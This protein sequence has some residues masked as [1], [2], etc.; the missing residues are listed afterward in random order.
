MSP[1]TVIIPAHNEQAVIT[2][3]L[4]LILKD[5][6]SG[7][8]VEIIVAA[9]GCSDR[10]AEVARAA[11]PSAQVLELHEG[12][13]TAAINAA[14]RVARHFPRIYLDADV[15][16]DFRS[17]AALAEVLR[18]DGVMTA[19]PAIRMDLAKCNVFMRAYYR[20]WLRQ[21]YARAGRGGAGCYGL[22]KAALTAVDEFPRIIADDI[23]IHARFPDSQKRYIAHNAA[24]LPVLSTVHPPRTAWQQIK[25]EARRQ[26]GVAQIRRLY[27]DLHSET[28]KQGEGLK[29]AL[30]SGCGPFDLAVFVLVKLAA[31]ARAR[32]NN[33]RGKGQEWARD[34]STRPAL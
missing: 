8:L 13:K 10:T 2:R 28:A 25:V 14:N 12:S 15:E 21:P 30:S 16:C 31:R 3:C 6:P 24:G 17:L 33:V 32:W 29:A 18:E 20:V 9:N 4:H 7:D 27:P 26:L 19:A 5:C 23:W 11:A 22:S 1:F 34:A